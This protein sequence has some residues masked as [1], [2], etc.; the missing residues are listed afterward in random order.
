MNVVALPSLFASIIAIFLGNFVLSRNVKGALNRI[1]FLYCLSA[2]F[3][4]FAEF[5]IRQATTIDEAY[6]WIKIS[7]VWPFIIA[8]MFHFVLVFTEKLKRLKKK[9]IYFLIYFPAI[10][11]SIVH[12]TSDALIGKPKQFSWGWTYSPP[13][14]GLIYDLA[15]IWTLI[16]VC[17]PLYIIFR[18]YKKST[19]DKKKKQALY[20]LI[21]IS[22]SA[23]MG[24]M[25][26]VILHDTG[27][28][29]PELTAIGYIFE[30][31]FIAFAIWKYELFRLTPAAA[32]EKII[33]TMSD[34]LILV[35]SE[36]RIVRVNQAALTLLGYKENE[37][38][39]QPMEILFANGEKNKS[40]KTLPEAKVIIEKD[41]EVNFKRKDE[42][43]LMVS[44][45]MSAIQD[46]LGINQGVIFTARDLT[47]RKR[48]EDQ[49]KASLK[50]KEILLKEIHHRVKN[51]LQTIISLLNL[52][53]SRIV[54]KQMLEVFKCSQERIRAMALI[55][56]KL[57][58]SEDLEKVDFSDYIQS[59]IAYLFDTYSLEPGQVQ[60]NMHVENLNLDRES[61]I[62][63][64]LI[65]NEL[66]SN[67]LK[68]AFPDNRKGELQIILRNC[69]DEEYDYILVVEDNGVGFPDGFDLRNSDTLGMM[70]IFTLVKQM[71]GVIGIEKKD[72]TSF[73]IKFKQSRNKKQI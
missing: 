29:L 55:H 26:E 54:D 19:E 8:F 21:G 73:T 61:A 43:E 1:F 15:N 12:A 62:P 13:E 71:R 36:G 18:Y 57:Y 9:L 27:I 42:R 5:E 49:I 33:S 10:T 22:I 44:L 53:S 14:N 66:I 34:A 25:T 28:N 63:L 48:M 24:I 41:M 58:E 31:S 51:N 16:M 40:K 6:L 67:T 35:S 20:I 68:H 30:C 56:E 50:E 4:A 3:S 2:A 70:I 72:G 52:Q 64:G 38:I 7:C 47:V 37:L 65:L 60:L 11:F 39:G 46:D 23:V 17:F 59:L 69:E 45:S 32:A